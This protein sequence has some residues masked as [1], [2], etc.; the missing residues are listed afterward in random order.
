MC[1]DLSDGGLP[2][3]RQGRSGREGAPRHG[4][5]FEAAE[6]A[7]AGVRFRVGRYQSRRP[8]AKSEARVGGGR[9]PRGQAWAF[10]RRL[11][12]FSWGTTGR[13]PGG[14]QVQVGGREGSK[15]VSSRKKR[16]GRP[17]PF[18]E[19]RPRGLRRSGRGRLLPV[20][21]GGVR[22]PPSGAH[23]LPR[24][25]H[26]ARPEVDVRLRGPRGPEGGCGPGR[27]W[28]PQ[29][30]QGFPRSRTRGRRSGLGPRASSGG[31]GSG[32]R[33]ACRGRTWQDRGR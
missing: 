3:R 9:G 33:E 26:G 31:R 7:F 20:A 2:G 12:G 23:V 10:T 29:A 6:G 13:T 17:G 14:A 4:P 22:T 25:A 16:S 21:H 30:V 1:A 18:F 8:R 15:P 32:V 19:S 11:C 27:R 28:M 24:P 5:V